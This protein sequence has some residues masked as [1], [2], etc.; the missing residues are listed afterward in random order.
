MRDH[1]AKPPFEPRHVITNSCRAEWQGTGWSAIIACTGLLQGLPH[2]CGKLVS[3]WVSIVQAIE[4][5]DANTLQPHLACQSHLH[6]DAPLIIKPHLAPAICI[7]T[8]RFA[9]SLGGWQR[10]TQE[11]PD[12]L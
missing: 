7:S 9:S 6:A 1:A 10:C 2:S 5:P 4:I 12:S 8:W 3:G 11:I